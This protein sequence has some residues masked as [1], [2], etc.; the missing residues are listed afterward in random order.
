MLSICIAG[1]RQGHSK[2]EREGSDGNRIEGE[3]CPRTPERK[4]SQTGESGHS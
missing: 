4:V 3:E 1:S 2:E